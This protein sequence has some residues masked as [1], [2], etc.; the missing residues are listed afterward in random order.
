MSSSAVGITTGGRGVLSDLGPVV[1]DNLH[2]HLREA[3]EWFPHQYIP[4]SRGRDFEGP[5][6]GEPWAPGQSRL[7][8]AAR[9]S[10]LLGVLT[11]DNLPS[12]YHILLRAFGERAPWSDWVHRWTAEE[13]RHSIAL[14]G[15]LLT[16]REVDPVALERFRMR[17]LT[18]GYRFDQ[19]GVLQ[20]LAY[21]TLQEW[22]TRVA[23]RNAG[24]AS[25][26]LVCD[27]MMGRIA[28]DENLHMIF[29][30]NVLQAALERD[31][32]AV[33]TAVAD[34]LPGFRLP[35]HVSADFAA[36]TRDIVAGGVYGARIHYEAVVA[37]FVRKLALLD[38]G[39]LRP[40]GHQAQERIARYVRHLEL[41]A[42]RDLPPR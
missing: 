20:A 5:Q 9:A 21:T 41:V 15:Y 22:A 40:E 36:L 33:L 31:P 10:L 6:N 38:I 7:S 14:R 4:W 19:D 16:A 25:G 18:T 11:E 26:D 12:Y 2:R 39:G 28:A 34:V 35:G 13:G 8:R 27:R 3:R 17:Q 29:Y 32:D 24:S 42:A 30:R 37:P 1:E 23:H